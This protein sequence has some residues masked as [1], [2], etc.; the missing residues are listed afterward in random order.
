MS[1][2]IEKKKNKGRGIFSKSRN[3]ILTVNW[4]NILISEIIIQ[5]QQFYTF[6]LILSTSFF[7]FQSFHFSHFLPN[8]LSLQTNQYYFSLYFS[9]FSTFFQNLLFS[10]L[11]NPVE[12]D[13]IQP[14]KRNTFPFCVDDWISGRSK[15]EERARIWGKK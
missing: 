3:K 11:L 12:K 13:H 14:S 10:P 8:I 15:Q 1:F 9:H 4:K 7:Y 6:I 5:F 2:E